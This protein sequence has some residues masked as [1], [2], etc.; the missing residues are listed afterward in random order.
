MEE[1]EFKLEVTDPGRFDEIAAAPEIV[2]AARGPERRLEMTA[3]YIDTEDLR[4][5]HAGYAYRVRYEG[6]HWVATVKAD[7]PGGGEDGLHRH[8]E[9]EAKVASPVPDLSVFADPDLK[10][11]LH[12]L[13]GDRSLTTLFRVDMERRIRQLEL[14]QGC[15]AEWAADRGR[16]LAGGKAEEVR[17][18]E[19]ELK[20]GPLEPVARLAEVLKA[21]YPLRPDSRTKFARGLKLAGLTPEPG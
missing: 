6:D 19:L 16:I 12:R 10:A 5:L 11:E 7:L 4:L 18:V 3:D 13:Q 8:R 21:H 2:G 9:W 15:Q 1:Q 17:E 20:A 14:A